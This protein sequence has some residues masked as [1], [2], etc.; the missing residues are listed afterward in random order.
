ML[1]EKY[2]YYLAN[3]PCQPNA[4]LEVTDKFTGEVVTCVAM[5]DTAAIDQA[6]AATVTACE[7]LAAMAS[8]ERQAI[9]NHCVT[10]FTER[11]DE[12]AMSLCIEAGTPIKDA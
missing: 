4:D 12:L 7:S 9:L 2:P 1:A 6:I 11:F 3:K 8:Y 5:A 10:R